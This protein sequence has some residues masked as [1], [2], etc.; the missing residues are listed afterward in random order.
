MGA[1]P[2]LHPAGST[3]GACSPLSNRPWRVDVL[4]RRALRKVPYIL[5][6]AGRAGRRWYLQKYF[7]R[8]LSNTKSSAFFF[9]SKKSGNFGIGFLSDET[10]IPK[11]SA[12]TV[13][14]GPMAKNRG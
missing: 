13:A 4:Q 9:N 8:L 7:L 11:V 10:S 14:Y 2:F 6:R 1:Q 3:T 5:V 12:R